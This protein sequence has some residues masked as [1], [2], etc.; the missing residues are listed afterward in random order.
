MGDR[1]QEVGPELLV[2]GRDGRAL[3]LL[4]GGAARE[5]KRRLAGDGRG[6]VGLVVAEGR[7]V[8]VDGQHSCHHGL[9]RGAAPGGSCVCRLG[10]LVVDGEVDAAG[11]L[12]RHLADQGRPHVGAAVQQRGQRRGKLLRQA[13]LARGQVGA[14]RGHAAVFLGLVPDAGVM[15]HAGQ[16]GACGV[17]DGPAVRAALQQAV[18]LEHDRAPALGLVG[19]VHLSPQG[20][21]RVAGDERRGEH[22]DKGA[23]VGRAH[24]R[25]GVARRGEEVVV[26]RHAQGR[27]QQAVEASDGDQRRDLHGHHVDDD[28]ARAHAQGVKPHAY[29]GGDKEGAQA[30]GQVAEVPAGSQGVRPGKGPV[31]A[32][33]VLPFSYAHLSPLGKRPHEGAPDAGHQDGRAQDDEYEVEPLRYTPAGKELVLVPL[34]PALVGQLA[35][36]LPADSHD[37]LPPDG[38]VAASAFRRLH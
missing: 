4:E 11:E 1:T 37:T 6:Y 21:G 22:D 13:L 24:R 30:K 23:G 17:D 27:A 25:E 18:G 28:H 5:G 32:D 9:R 12:R 38:C 8:D 7:L 31:G 14:R 10:R 19:A 16:L 26:E 36:G 3:A 15:R 20:H 33:G 35:R 2:L 29:Q 34:K